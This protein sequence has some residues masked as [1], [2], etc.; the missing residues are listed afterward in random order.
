MNRYKYRWHRKNESEVHVDYVIA[1]DVSAATS[2]IHEQW[3][4]HSSERGGLRI[5]LDVVP[6]DEQ[7]S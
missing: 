2:R 1:N 6:C 4:G 3:G 5:L 7:A